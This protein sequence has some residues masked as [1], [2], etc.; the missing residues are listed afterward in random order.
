MLDNI[1]LGLL[2]YKSLSVY[3]IKKA[4]DV[5]VSFFYS[6]S[7]GNIIPALKKLE[8]NQYVTITESV[9]NG[10]NRKEYTITD[11]GRAKFKEWLAQNVNIGK[12]QDEALLKLFFLTEIPVEKRIKMLEEY[13][14][15]LNE[16]IIELKAVESETRKMDVDQKYKEA[17]NYRIS[18]LEF[19]IH[20]Y[21]F[22]LTWYN[23]IIDKI[24]RKEL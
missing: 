17:F 6:S 23:N 8:V 10:R 11:N 12:I 5:T 22:E 13:T 15:K 19:G 3:D 9:L 2:L 14:V 7:Y 16:K 21:Q 24:K 4:I 18:T 1:I 20:Y